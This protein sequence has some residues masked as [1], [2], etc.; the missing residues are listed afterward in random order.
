MNTV[1]SH[2]DTVTVVG[3]T[4]TLELSIGLPRVLVFAGDMALGRSEQDGR[5]AI[6]SYRITSLRTATYTTFE[7]AVTALATTP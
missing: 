5:L 1:I 2:P 7:E 6:N 4:Y 3:R